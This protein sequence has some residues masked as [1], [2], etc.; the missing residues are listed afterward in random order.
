MKI[1]SHFKSQ[2]QAYFIKRLG[3]F[4]YKHGWLRVPT[5][6]YCQRENKLGINLSLFRTNC[7]R[8]NSHPSPTQLIMDIEG[9]TEYHEL[10]KY[11]GS[12]SFDGMVFK[13]EKVELVESKLLYL[14]EG[15]KNISYGTSQLAKGIRKY[16]E[17]RGFDINYLSKLG[18]GYGTKDKYFGYLIIP[19]YDQGKLRYYNARSVIGN[20]PRYNNPDKDITGLGKE[21]IIFNQDA[22]DLYKSVFI[23]EGAINA[24]TLGDKAI[25]T[26]G[27]AVSAYQIN[28]LIKSNCERYILLLDPDAKKYALNLALKLVPYKKVKVVIL[29]EGKDVNDLGKADT[30]KLVYQT[31]YQSYQDL[32]KLKNSFDK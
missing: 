16:M 30:L 24:L 26:M 9:F 17:G 12:G 15:F 4:Q 8:C 3:A 23:C 2:L 1:T 22:L 11:L 31:R 25:A 14:P 6:P 28:T 5:C 29:P 27:K 18:I 13:E 21:F 19:F 10:I 32:V 20:G 7:F